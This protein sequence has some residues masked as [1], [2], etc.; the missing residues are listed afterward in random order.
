MLLHFIIEAGL[1]GL[2]HP[3]NEEKEQLKQYTRDTSNLSD[4]FKDK[5]PIKIRIGSCPT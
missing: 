2:K 5:I 1:R 4:E 3:T